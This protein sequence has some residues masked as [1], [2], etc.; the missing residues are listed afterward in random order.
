METPLSSPQKDKN[1]KTLSLAPSI[2]SITNPNTVKIPEDANFVVIDLRS[3]EDYVAGH[4]KNSILFPA[5]NIN[6]DRIHPILLKM[7]NQEGKL[8]ILYAADDKSGVDAAQ[9]F[10]Q[11]NYLN[12][13]L[14]TGGFGE[15]ARIGPQFIE[16]FFYGVNPTIPMT[17]QVRLR[18]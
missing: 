13:Y 6:R 17:P 3:Y 12:V 14:L 1:R 2:L 5:I 15:F 16:G 8:I 10:C 9:Q 4:I 18:S 11:R 7:K